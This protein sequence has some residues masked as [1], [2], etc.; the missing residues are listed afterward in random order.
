MY[1]YI[2]ILSIISLYSLVLLLFSGYVLYIN[3]PLKKVNEFYISSY[4]ICSANTLL[5]FSTIP[6]FFILKD[7]DRKDYNIEIIYA[8]LSLVFNIYWLTVIFNYK[9]PE[10]FHDYSI[11]KTSEFFMI[12]LILIFITII[13]VPCTILK[14]LKK[15][16]LINDYKE[17]ITHI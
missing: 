16:N 11:I 1:K 4:I 9:I 5:Y 8:L 17:I 14:K 2:T 7:K 15:N 6:V 12:I 13:I 10:S 3:I